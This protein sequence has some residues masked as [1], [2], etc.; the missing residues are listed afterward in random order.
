[1]EITYN[2]NKPIKEKIIEMRNQRASISEIAYAV[3]LP[4]FLVY[5]VL[6]KT[7]EKNAKRN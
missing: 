7:G 2:I 3:Q 4:A 1:M 6:H 5:K